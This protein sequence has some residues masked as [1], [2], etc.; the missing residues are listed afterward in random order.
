MR[1]AYL[2]IL[3]V[4]LASTPAVAQ[5]GNV[6]FKT[7]SAEETGIKAIMQRWHDAELARQGGKFGSH[8]WWPW[9]LTAFDYDS[10]GDVDLLPTQHGVPRGIVLKS[11]FHESGKLTFVDVTKELGIDGRDLPISDGKPWVWDF[12]GDGWLDICLLYT[13]PSPRDATLSRMPSSA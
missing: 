9:G 3:C 10:D 6:S 1:S 11:L 7:V 8:G 12:D 4:M 2:T 13:S 5:E